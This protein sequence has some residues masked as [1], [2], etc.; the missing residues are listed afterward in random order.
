MIKMP[1]QMAELGRNTLDAALTLANLSMESAEKLMH[2]Q[3]AAAKVFV[4]EQTENARALA[5]AREPEALL[6]LRNK[7]TEQAVERA[8]GFSR[9]VYE[10]ATQTQ[11]EFAKVLENRFADYQQEMTG[12]VEQMFQNAP[13]GSEAAVA[14]VKSS[15][16]AMQSAIGSL[17]KAAQ[18]VAEMAD[19]NLKTTIN[20]AKSGG[21]KKK[22]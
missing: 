14:A 17:T 16:A 7:L 4:A 5:Q 8:F 18:Q 3:L 19:A 21:T 11:S 12:T 15:F 20:A 10:I 2:L 1:E 9:N 6:A 13:A 22:A